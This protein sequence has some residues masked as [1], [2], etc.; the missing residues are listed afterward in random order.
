MIYLLQAGVSHLQVFNH[1]EVWSYYLVHNSNYNLVSKV[2]KNAKVGFFGK[3]LSVLVS[4][5]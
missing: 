3:A 1:T 5:Q 4:S 2:E